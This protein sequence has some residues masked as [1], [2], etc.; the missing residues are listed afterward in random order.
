MNYT[1]SVLGWLHRS[2]AAVGSDRFAEAAS[3]CRFSL[4]QAAGLAK[5]PAERSLI[6]GLTDT[7]EAVIKADTD[8]RQLL[9]DAVSGISETCAGELDTLLETME[10]PA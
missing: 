9:D 5:T 7:L 1:F 2:S 4:N 10:V 3:R 6:D 8:S